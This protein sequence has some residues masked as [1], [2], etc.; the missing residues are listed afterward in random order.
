MLETFRNNAKDLRD[1]PTMQDEIPSPLK[2]KE[3]VIDKLKEQREALE[4]VNNDMRQKQ[5]L[6]GNEGPI[7]S[8]DSL[9][10][11]MKDIDNQDKQKSLYGMNE[12]QLLVH[13]QLEKWVSQRKNEGARMMKK[14]KHMDLAKQIF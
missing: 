10:K 11:I 8:K 4:N 7:V 13:R 12:Q 6:S 5:T 1:H 3:I 14:M 2:Q 9:I